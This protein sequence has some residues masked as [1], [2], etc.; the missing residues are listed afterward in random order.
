M[1]DWLV[2]SHSDIIRY[3]MTI[4]EACRLVLEAGTVDSGGEIFVFDM[5]ESLK[6]ADLACR[7]IELAGFRP[8]KGICN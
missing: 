6:I 4:P 7:V 1:M 3:F 5:D 2:V 8:C